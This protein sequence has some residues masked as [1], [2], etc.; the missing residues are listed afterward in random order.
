MTDNQEARQW[1]QVVFNAAA[2]VFFGWNA[3]QIYGGEPGLMF[4]SVEGV[5]TNWTTPEGWVNWWVAAA[6]GFAA[7][8]MAAAFIAEIRKPPP[9]AQATSNP[10][11]GESREQ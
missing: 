7:L 3:A 6:F 9:G 4:K 10:D 5:F 8:V 11:T 2:G 1:R